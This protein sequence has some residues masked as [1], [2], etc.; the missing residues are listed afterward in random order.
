MPFNRE[1]SLFVELGLDDPAG[2]MRLAC[3]PSAT[4]DSVRRLSLARAGVSKDV[5]HIKGSKS[6]DNYVVGHARVGL[7]GLAS[8]VRIPSTSV[9]GSAMLCHRNSSW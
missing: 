6:W 9:L 5:K 3:Q 1:G 8:I 2:S 4:T 7:G